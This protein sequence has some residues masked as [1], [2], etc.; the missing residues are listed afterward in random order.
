VRLILVRHGATEWS[1]SGQHTGRTDLPLVPEGIEEGRDAAP[2]LAAVLAGLGGGQHRAVSSPLQRALVTAALMLPDEP[3]EVVDELAELD[4]GQYEGLTKE[5]IRAD[6]PGWDIWEDGCPGGESVDDVGRRADRFLERIAD[7][8]STVVAF[9]HGHTLRIVAARALGLP[10]VEGR[11]FI[12]DTA[13]V[14]VLE[15]SD[16]EVA[17]RLWNRTPEARSTT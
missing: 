6:R 4:Y 10:A 5:E 1:R 2:V 13:S 15:T 12:A 7:D 16:G 17:V 9:S 14:S 11:R 8:D 3:I